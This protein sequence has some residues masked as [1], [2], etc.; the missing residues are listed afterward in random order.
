MRRF[1]AKVDGIDYDFEIP[2][3]DHCTG[4]PQL[5][6]TDEARRDGAKRW[7]CEVFDV[8]LPPGYLYGPAHEPLR[9][10]VETAPYQG[11]RKR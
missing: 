8:E 7:Y 10:C 2:N 1:K 9:I 6:K 5:R 4:C 3:H 11:E